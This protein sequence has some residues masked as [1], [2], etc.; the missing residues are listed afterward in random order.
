[1]KKIILS[2][3]LFLV[4]FLYKPTLSFAECVPRPGALTCVGNIYCKI[5]TGVNCCDNQQEC[6]DLTAKDNQTKQTVAGCQPYPGALT[7]VGRTYCKTNAGTN[8]CVDQRACDELTAM[9]NATTN[10]SGNQDPTAGCG[11][12]GGSINSAIGCIPF[13]DNSTFLGWILGWAV[14]V[15]GGVAFLLIAL[16]TITIMTSQGNPDKIKEGQEHLTS[17]ISGLILLIFTVFVLKFIGIDILGLKDFG[18][19]S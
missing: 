11:G 5:S 9:D 15:G 13:K 1:M 18:F 4:I 10:S 16:A 3:F 17:A 12:D 2:L 7:C 14:G 8:C 6:D 19:G